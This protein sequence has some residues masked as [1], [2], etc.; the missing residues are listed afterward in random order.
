MSSTLS[1]IVADLCDGIAYV[2]VLQVTTSEVLDWVYTVVFIFSV[3]FGI[4][5][6]IYSALQDRKITKQEEED[7]K[8]ELQDGLSKIDSHITK[9]DDRHKQE[10]HHDSDNII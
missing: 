6:K 4:F 2:A 3:L 9:Q 10:E 7:I 8:K 1:Y 5:M